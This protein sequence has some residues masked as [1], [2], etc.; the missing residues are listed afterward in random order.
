MMEDK[1]AKNP[2]CNARISMS[3]GAEAMLD[4]TSVIFKIYNNLLL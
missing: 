2:G 4:A 1:I 3:R